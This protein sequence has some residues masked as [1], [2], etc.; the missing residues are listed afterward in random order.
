MTLRTHLWQIWGAESESELKFPQS[1][2]STIMDCAIVAHSLTTRLQI[3]IQYFTQE[4]PTQ[5]NSC[6]QKKQKA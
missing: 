4:V 3:L 1:A 6:Y 2:R 5:K